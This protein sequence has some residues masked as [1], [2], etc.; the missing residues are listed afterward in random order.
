VATEP[1]TAGA[2]AT[3]AG[4]AP[5]VLSAQNLGKTFRVRGGRV[6]A[7]R[8][9]QAVHDVSLELHEEK[10]LALVGESGCGKS[11]VARLLAGLYRPTT[12][13]IRLRGSQIGGR[14]E[15]ARRRFTGHVQIVLQDPFSSLNAAYSVRHHLVRPLVLH[16]GRQENPDGDLEQASIE[17]LEEVNLT[18]GPDFLDR[19]PHELSGGQRQRVSIA[20]A[21]AV[22]PEV[23]LADE[24]V[25]MLDVSLRLSVLR[26]LAELT[27][28]R[29]LALLYI[30]HDIASARYFADDIAVMYAGEMV[31]YG[32]AEQVTQQP[33][34]P[35]TQLLVSAVPDP[36]RIFGGGQRTARGEAPNLAAPPSGCRFAP[37]CPHVMERCRQEA[38]PALD[39]G[40]GRWARCWL[41]DGSTNEAA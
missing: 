9:V 40:P 14:G 29:R 27:R 18:P 7:G 5:A 16:R 22:R 32:P 6:T 34:H 38:P 36:D 21:L 20:R 1:G 11:T 25:S 8:T 24:P 2:Q 28:S 3:A 31:E 33:S 13:T 12:G 17:L 15:R 4:E 10:V 30:T 37:R 41:L 35:Y 26:L 23:M 19:Y 39:A